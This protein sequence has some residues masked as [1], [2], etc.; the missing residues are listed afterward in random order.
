[1]NSFCE[2]FNFSTGILVETQ[3]YFSSTEF[4]P[5][6]GK[7]ECRDNYINKTNC[8]LYEIWSEEFKEYLTITCTKNSKYLK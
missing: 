8:E 1:M 3:N 7:L 5:M 4:N 2:L 6:I